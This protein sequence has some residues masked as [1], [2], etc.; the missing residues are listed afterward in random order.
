MHLWARLSSFPWTRIFG[1]SVITNVD[2]MLGSSIQVLAA[3]LSQLTSLSNIDTAYNPNNH[4]I[5]KFIRDNWNIIEN[6]AELHKIF[7]EPEG[8][9]CP[10]GGLCRQQ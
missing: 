1:S 7:P 9:K 3:F 5:I 8:K 6:T 2:H 4:R 10:K